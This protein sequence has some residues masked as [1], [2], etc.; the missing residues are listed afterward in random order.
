MSANDGSVELRGQAPR[1]IVDVLDA[2]SLSRRITRWELV[3]EILTAWADTTMKE[4]TAVMRVA[5]G[6]GR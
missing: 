5:A 1:L 4:A 2:I 6:D 3:N